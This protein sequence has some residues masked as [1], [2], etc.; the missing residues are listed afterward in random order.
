MP[1][2]AGVV[3]EGL[4]LY[5]PVPVLI[6]EAQQ[7]TIIPLDTPIEGRNGQMMDHIKVSKGTAFTTGQSSA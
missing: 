4:R 6:Q 1:I 3:H 7:D 5:P 2:L